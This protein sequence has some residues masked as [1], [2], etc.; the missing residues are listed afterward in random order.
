MLNSGTPLSA[1]ALTQHKA[2]AE[3]F[4]LN[5]LPQDTRRVYKV[6]HGS[7]RRE[8]YPPDPCWLTRNR[9]KPIYVSTYYTYTQSY[10]KIQY[11]YSTLFE[12]GTLA[13][14]EHSLCCCCC[15]CR[16][17]AEACDGSEE[18]ARKQASSKQTIAAAELPR[19]GS[20]ST[21]QQQQR[22]LQVCCI[23]L[24]FIEVLYYVLL[25]PLCCLGLFHK[26]PKKNTHTHTNYKYV[27]YNSSIFVL[28]TALENHVFWSSSDD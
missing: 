7:L 19:C 4:F 6:Y 28:L 12:G 1:Q 11:K 2:P 24:F 26:V 23:F 21:K 27:L 18:E 13:L 15:Y 17:T 25:H 9:I 10:T 20:R 8:K 3:Q 5:S 14:A 22:S 16:S